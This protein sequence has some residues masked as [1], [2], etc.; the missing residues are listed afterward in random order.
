MSKKLPISSQLKYTIICNRHQTKNDKGSLC[1]GYNYYDVLMKNIKCTHLSK[2]SW[3]H[4]LSF[5]FEI[6]LIFILPF[7]LRTSG[8]GYLGE[9]VAT[10]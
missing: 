1:S 6:E 8:E 5:C 10:C 2:G 9:A 4:K 7:P 3:P